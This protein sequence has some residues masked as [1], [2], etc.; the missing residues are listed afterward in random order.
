MYNVDVPIVVMIYNR[1][2]QV[3]KLMEQIRKVAPK[4]LFIVSD[5]PKNSKH[6]DF[7]LVKD[8]RSIAERVDWP[9]SITKIYSDHNLGLR[10]RFFSGLDQVFRDTEFAIILEDD[11]HPDTTFFRF[12][13]ELLRKYEFD[14]RI[15]MI[16]GNNFGD[17][18]KSP[19]SYRFSYSTNIWGWA[20]WRR[21]WLEFAK[22]RNRTAYSQNDYKQ[23]RDRFSDSHSRK[24]FYKFMRH[25]NDLKTWDISF[26]YFSRSFGK[27][28]V[29]P[30][31]NL[32]TN[33][34]FGE[35]S[36]HTKFESFADQVPNQSI[37]FPL[38]HPPLVEFNLKLDKKEAREK[39]VR[40]WLFI[41]THPFDFVQRVLRYTR[42]KLK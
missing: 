5:G 29:V 16:S 42:N 41:V 37:D 28:S 35:D 30:A 19:Y 14:E 11:C 33:Q 23:I 22:N 6:S 25:E 21:T 40:T 1:P 13:S 18:W 38:I 17:S 24:L 20:T 10:E 39:R 34:G 15:S 8:S 27:L 26:G 4:Q 2:Y 12:C 9:C 36:T 3:Q 31:R 7:Q 32:V